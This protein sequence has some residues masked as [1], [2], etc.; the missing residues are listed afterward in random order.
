MPVIYLSGVSPRHFSGLPSDMERAT[1]ITPVY[2]TLQLLRRTARHVTMRLVGSYST[3]SPLPLPER[4][5]GYFLLRYSTLTD[6]FLLGSGT[7]C[8]ARTFLIRTRRKRQTD[9]L[10]YR[11]QR[12]GILM[13][14]EEWRMKNLLC[15]VRMQYGWILH[16]SFFTLNYLKNMYL[17]RNKFVALLLEVTKRV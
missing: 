13:K 4:N 11:V 14:N 2:M 16:S 8:V 17:F 5:G 9:Q 7:L 10:L 6:S 15:S 12:Y 3:F 1:L